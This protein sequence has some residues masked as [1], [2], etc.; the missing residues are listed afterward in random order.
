MSQPPPPAPTPHGWLELRLSAWSSS[1]RAELDG[2]AVPIHGE[3]TTMTVAPGRHRLKVWYLHRF[4]PYGEEEID[5]D[6]PPGQ[7]VRAYYA[8]PRHVLGKANLGLDPQTR[9]SA[10]SG[11][12]VKESCLA[13]LGCL[14][15]IL[16]VAV[17]WAVGS[18]V[19]ESVGG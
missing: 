1:H 10:V 6:V 17:V 12:E 8:M 13:T 7:L 19:W 15:L 2:V 11:R 18:V 3:V 14:G 9:S 4:A 5:V 16:L